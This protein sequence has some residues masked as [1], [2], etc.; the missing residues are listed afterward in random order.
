MTVNTSAALL[1]PSPSPSPEE[2]K[3]GSPYC[4]GTL[5]PRCFGCGA[6]YK[7][8]EKFTV[9]ANNANGNSSRPYAKCMH[10]NKFVSWLDARGIDET[11]PPCSCG[12]LCRRQVAGKFGNKNPRAL[13]YV[14]SL[15]ICDFYG[16]CRDEDGDEQVAADELLDLLARLNVI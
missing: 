9:N 8:L 5:L 11:C 13:H 15:G 2:S 6:K 1:S 4:K 12:K 10:C 7:E 16:L 3:S 14:C